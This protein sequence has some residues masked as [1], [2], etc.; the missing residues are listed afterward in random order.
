MSWLC[1]NCGLIVSFYA[2][3]GTSKDSSYLKCYRCGSRNVRKKI[4][5]YPCDDF[6]K[7]EI[8]DCNC[9]AGDGKLDDMKVCDGCYARAQELGC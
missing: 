3:R 1:N 5:K 8:P 2:F 6:M 7:C 4:R 9:E